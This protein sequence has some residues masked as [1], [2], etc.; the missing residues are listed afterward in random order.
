MEIV[1]LTIAA[2]LTSLLTALIGLGGGVVLMLLMPGLMPLAAIIPVHAV[3]QFVSNLS[4]VGFALGEVDWKLI[5]PLLLGSV[6][7]AALGSQ[8]VGLVSLDWLPAVA[9]VLILL[10]TWLPAGKLIP[11]G[12]RALVLLGF[13][14]TSLGMLA[15]ATGPLGAAVLAKIRAQREWL[16]VNTGVYMMLNHGVRALTFALMG[17]AFAPWLDTI[18]WM[19][20]G[21]TAGAWVGTRLR[22]RLPQK[23]FDVIFRWLVTVLALRMVALTIVERTG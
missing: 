20:L 22:Q 16:V 9:G 15:G 8:T 4:R 17:F 19:S 1:W 10:V 13:Y 18:L 14:Q 11:T 21:M 5:P 12:P 2:L 7:G 6:A 3:V 23:N